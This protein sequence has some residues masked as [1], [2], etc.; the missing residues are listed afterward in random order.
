MSFSLSSC[1]LIDFVSALMTATC[2]K[3][4]SRKDPF[5]DFSLAWPDSMS[6]SEDL[7]RVCETV[8]LSPPWKVEGWRASARLNKKR[9]G[10]ACEALV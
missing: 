8:L 3:K 4:S 7:L 10:W 5:E 9:T 1:L 2:L 6:E